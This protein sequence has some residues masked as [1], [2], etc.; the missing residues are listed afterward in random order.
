MWPRYRTWMGRRVMTRLAAFTHVKFSRSSSA[1][2]SR[3]IINSFVSRS[4]HSSPPSLAPFFLLLDFSRSLLLLLLRGPTSWKKKR[5][6]VKEYERGFCFY[7]SL[8]IFFFFDRIL[9]ARISYFDFFLSPRILF[10]WNRH[11][12][13][14]FFLFLFHPIVSTI[15]T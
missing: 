2:L 12:S 10:P 14:L 8:F 6:R 7:L 13:I 4:P 5:I 9:V 3:G 1:P 11:A 15:D